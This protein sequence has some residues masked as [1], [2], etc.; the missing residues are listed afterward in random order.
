MVVV[1]LETPAVAVRF[2]EIEHGK[3]TGVVL[4]AKGDWDLLSFQR[5]LTDLYLMAKRLGIEWE[6]T[7]KAR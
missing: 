4:W 2:Q 7:D 5:E 1:V 6:R 3:W